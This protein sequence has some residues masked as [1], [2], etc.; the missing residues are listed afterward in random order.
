MCTI[1]LC[2]R[3]AATNASCAA[4]GRGHS[5]ARS[6]INPSIRIKVEVRRKNRHPGS[7]P[8]SGEDRIYWQHEQATHGPTDRRGR[9]CS[10]QVVGVVSVEEERQ[11]KKL[12][13]KEHSTQHARAQASVITP[14][15]VTA[16]S[17]AVLRH[18]TGARHRAG[19]SHIA[20]ARYKAS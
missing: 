7:A 2:C 5:L 10:Q 9:C 15:A 20:G 3:T 16:A 4:L 12:A 8:R 6:V 18:V 19:A 13:R 1:P 17:P 14:A 11:K